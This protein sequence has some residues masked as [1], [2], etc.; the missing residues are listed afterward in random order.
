MP[1]SF[2]RPEVEALAPY[3]T[4]RPLEDLQREL[5]LA[6]IVKLAANEGPF[7]PFPA[8]IEAMSRAQGELNRYPN[9]GAVRLHEAIASR[10]G[11][12]FDETCA[13]AGADGCIDLL[14]QAVLGPGDEIVSAWPSFPS[15]E[16]YAA[17]Q[18]ASTTRVP[19]DGELR[20]DLNALAGAIGARTKLVYV[21]HP[22]NPTSTMNTK[23]ELD[24]FLAR[25]P[26]HVLVVIDQAY[27]EYIDRPDYP[28]AV[29]YFKDGARVLVLRTFSK[30]YGLAGLRV[31][32]AVGP[33]DV[34][35]AMAKVRRPFDVTTTAQIAAVAS[36]ADADEIARRR[37]ANAR[38]LGRLIEIVEENGLEAAPGAVGNFVYVETGEDAAGLFGRFLQQ[39]VI[40][41]DLGS[42]GAP[43]AIRV[44]VGT[45]EENEVF[46]AALAAVRAS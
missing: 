34:C 39:G 38:G 4:G 7:P 42:F 23:D 18:G 12:A 36:I 14:S 16:I 20:T 9:G 1:G 11:V 35:A 45:P 2:F 10:H 44:S 28:D 33:R 19:L 6:R 40:V 41:R 46:A 21:C 13:G 22:N 17:K 27:F 5:G 25:V 26:P 32:Y 43:T 29:S 8:A 24:A 37:A 3:A 31:G 15:Y 30:I